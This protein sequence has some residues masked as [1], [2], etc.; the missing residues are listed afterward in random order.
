MLHLGFQG[1]TSFRRRSLR[2]FW[3]LGYATC[4]HDIGVGKEA[5]IAVRVPAR[6]PNGAKEPLWK[7]LL[8]E[9]CDLLLQ[10]IILLKGWIQLN[11]FAGNRNLRLDED[12][13][14]KLGRIPLLNQSEKQLFQSIKAATSRF[15]L[16]DLISGTMAFLLPL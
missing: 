9:R 3:F 13:Q 10:K 4:V 11:K 5:L 15:R 12:I 14:S 2:L 8:D 7:F 6:K 16:D 1:R